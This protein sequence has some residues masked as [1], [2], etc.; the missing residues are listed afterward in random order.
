MRDLQAI[1]SLLVSGD[2]CAVK[3]VV[4]KMQRHGYNLQRLI[5]SFVFFSIP[6]PNFVLLIFLFFS[7]FHFST[8]RFL[9]WLVAKSDVLQSVQRVRFLSSFCCSRHHFFSACCTRR[10]FRKT[11]N[12]NLKF[13]VTEMPGFLFWAKYQ[14]AFLRTRNLGKPKKPDPNFSSNPNVHP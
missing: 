4:Q 11:R 8:F 6:F 2:L 12:P 14:V 7:S 13:R 1:T 3:C 9:F 10:V 5:L